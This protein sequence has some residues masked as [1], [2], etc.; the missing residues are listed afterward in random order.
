MS[1]KKY[2]LSIRTTKG[3]KILTTVFYSESDLSSYVEKNYKDCSYTY[4]QI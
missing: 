1:L 3:N 2:L 4:R